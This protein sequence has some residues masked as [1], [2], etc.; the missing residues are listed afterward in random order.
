[1]MR[2]G[3]EGIGTREAS[4]PRDLRVGIPSSPRDKAFGV[5]TPVDVVETRTSR[6]EEARKRV[7][8]A[9]QR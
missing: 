2:I 7:D 9:A 1:M 6:A 3:P 8:L 5:A 4:S